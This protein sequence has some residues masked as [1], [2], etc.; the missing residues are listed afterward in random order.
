MKSEYP[1]SQGHLG[2]HELSLVLIITISARLFLGLPRVMSTIGAT[3]SWMA[4]TIAFITA[5]AGFFCLDSLLVRFPGSDLIE[6][7]KEVFGDFSFVVGV[8]LFL[9]FW[10]A[11]ALLMRQFAE[12][13]VISIL[14]RTPIGVIS[15]VLLI[16]LIA[17]SYFGIECISRLAML[18][19]P[20]ICLCFLLV[21]LLVLPNADFSHLLPFWGSGLTRMTLPSLNKSSIFTEIVLLGLWAP[22]L[23]E[24]KRRRF[25]GL[26]ALSI[27][28]LIMVISLLIFTAVFDYPSTAKIFFPIYQLTRMI[29]LMA[30]F[31]RAEAIFVFVWVFTAAISLAT[32]FYSSAFILAR[33]FSLTTHR[34]LLF[35]L[36]VMTYALSLLPGSITE[37]IGLDNDLLHNYG[38]ILAFFLPLL[39][40][41]TAV[42]RRRKGVIGP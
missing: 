12:I 18:F 2:Y 19:G 13:F 14:P 20:Y 22:L 24:P 4:V 38:W 36:A 39:M 34:P 40:L 16:I 32:I 8:L 5:V 10:A 11:G 33:T 7:A 26:A 37:T 41:I 42:M 30:F 6:I 35:P 17:A 29:N 1:S 21:L 15:G 3:A 23:R 31:Q 9:F 25:I 27:S 28:Y